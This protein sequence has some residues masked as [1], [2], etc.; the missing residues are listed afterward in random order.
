MSHFV[1][2]NRKHDYAFLRQMFRRRSVD[3][4]PLAAS[5]LRRAIRRRRFAGEFF[6]DAIELGERLKTHFKC[7]LA[8]SN[9]AAFLV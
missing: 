6:E 4:A 9:G 5:Q 8:D 2:D 7:D 3:L 1:P